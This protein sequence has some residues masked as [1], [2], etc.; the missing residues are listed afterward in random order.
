MTSWLRRRWF[1]LWSRLHRNFDGTDPSAKRT[2][3]AI[4]ALLTGA[5][6]LVLG[7]AATWVS[8]A[9]GAPPALTAWLAVWLLLSVFAV[10]L[11]AVGAGPGRTCR[12]AMTA[13]ILVTCV[14]LLAALTWPS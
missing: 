5:S 13:L 14:V 11:I 4:W 10:A 9:V 2:A 1:G 3:R 6:C 8:R 7:R 12:P